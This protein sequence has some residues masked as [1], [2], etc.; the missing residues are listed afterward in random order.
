MVKL[1]EYKACK[2][3]EQKKEL[4]TELIEMYVEFAVPAV[5]LG[6]LH[7]AHAHKHLH[8][9]IR[10]THKH[11]PLDPTTPTH[12]RTHIRIHIYAIL[13]LAPP[14]HAYTHAHAHLYATCSWPP[15]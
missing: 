12:A 15:F 7:H 2:D 9:F 11:D 8:T 5:S 3:K 1:E 10:P 13:L 6:V 14:R 4:Q